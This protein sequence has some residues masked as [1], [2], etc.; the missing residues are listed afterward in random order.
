[1]SY[2][3]DFRISSMKYNTNALLIIKLCN[4]Y[5]GTYTITIIFLHIKKQNIKALFRD[6]L[7]ILKN[8]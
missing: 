5:I 1:M 4:W 7:H 2:G 3:V 8:T 6:P